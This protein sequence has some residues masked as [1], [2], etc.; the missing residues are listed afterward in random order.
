MTASRPLPTPVMHFTH[1]DHLESVIEHGLVAD[2]W[3]QSDG[4]LAV[5]IG[6]VEVKERRR[7]A[8][9][10]VGAGGFVGDYVPFYFAPRSPMMFVIHKGAVPSYRG[11]CARLVYLVT[12]VEILVDA[13]LAPV[14]TDRNAVLSFAQFSGS[15]D[16]LDDLIDW[17]LMRARMWNNTSA[18]PDRMERR[19]AEC[20]VHG[21]VPW[22]VI[23]RV[24]AASDE[25][26]GDARAIL[27]NVGVATP[28]D[29]RRGW[30]F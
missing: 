5:E 29:V 24:V 14:F 19:M 1:I 10:P 8:P 17:P 2:S 3:A 15:I 9:V 4:H 18:D 26:A 22:Q 13:G 12:S 7:T 11:G 16:Q 30:Y 20:L 23:E 25:A 6:N 27:A 21:A 28:V